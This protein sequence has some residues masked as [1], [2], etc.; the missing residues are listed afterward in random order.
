MTHSGGTGTF[1]EK[2]TLWACAPVPGLHF[3]K[4]SS[5]SV[6]PFRNERWK[7]KALYSAKS[8]IFFPFT[9]TFSLAAP[10]PFVRLTRN[11]QELLRTY[12]RVDLQSFVW[13]RPPAARQTCF[14][15]KTCVFR[16][17]FLH[18]CLVRPQVST[19]SAKNSFA[20]ARTHIDA[21][22]QQVSERS[23]D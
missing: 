16:V 15:V 1:R 18:I 9:C 8:S 6:E 5:K 12:G 2:R 11:S 20:T 7:R 3:L 22:P 14:R 23:N 21:C 4:I 10:K 13:I 17:F 19:I